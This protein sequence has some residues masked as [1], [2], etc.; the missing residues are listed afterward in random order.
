MMRQIY[1]DTTIRFR[2]FAKRFGQT[3]ARGK[4][5]QIHHRDTPR[6]PSHAAG[7][8]PTRTGCWW[9]GRRGPDACAAAA[10]LSSR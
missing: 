8:S 6:G 4:D 3:R 9:A 5:F 7:P 1:A 10:A 2:G